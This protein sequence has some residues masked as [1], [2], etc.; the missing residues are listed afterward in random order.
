MSSLNDPAS[1]LG[2]QEGGGEHL[3]DVT[4]SGDEIQAANDSYSEQIPTLPVAVPYLEIAQSELGLDTQAALFLQRLFSVERYRINAALTQSSETE[5]FTH[6]CQT[7][8]QQNISPGFLFDCDWVAEQLSSKLDR[9]IDTDAESIM[10]LWLDHECGYA[11]SV[12]WFDH[13]FYYTTYPDVADAGMDA[14]YH[15]VMNGMDEGR[16]PTAHLMTVVN[17]T[18]THF[19]ESNISVADIIKAVPTDSVENYVTGASYEQQLKLFMPEL[20][21]ATHDLPGDYTP[22]TLF[23]HF[24]TVGLLS[25]KRPSALFNTDFYRSQVEALEQTS[26]DANEFV[27]PLGNNNPWLHWFYI[28]KEHNVVPTPLFSEAHYLSQHPDIGNNYEGNPFE[29]YLTTGHTEASRVPSVHFDA[30][31]YRAMNSDRKFPSL[32]LDYIMNGQFVPIAPSAG[33]HIEHFLSDDPYECSPAEKAAI[34]VS[35]KVARLTTGVLADMVARIDRLEPQIVRPYTSKFYR[36]APSFH[37]EVDLMLD[38]RDAVNGLN[39]KQYDTI[40][41]IPHCRMAGSAKIAGKL[42]QVLARIDKPEN[43]LVI[44]TDMS[45]F[46]RPDW[47]PE[48]VDVYDLNQYTETAPVDRKMRTLL[49]IVRGLRPKRLVNVNSNFGWQLTTAYGRQLS[50]WM[51][52]YFYLFCWDLDIKGNKGG[53]PIQWFLPTFDYCKAVFTDSKFLRDELQERYCITDQQRMKLQVLHTPAEDTQVNYHQ[54]LTQRVESKSV[55]RV[56]WSGRFDRQ[57]RTDILLAVAAAMPDIEF[58]VWGKVVLGDE[59]DPMSELPDNV[60]L[61]GHYSSID[62]VPIASCDCFLYT[63]EWDGLPTVLIEVGSRSVPIVA[64]AVGGVTDLITPS[65]GW[66][67]EDYNNAEAYVHAIEQVLADYPA[68]LEKGKA[69]REHTLTVCN[70]ELFEKRLAA[71]LAATG[72]LRV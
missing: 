20:Y 8:I 26:L 59:E 72:E 32:V 7:G 31:Y 64:S 36:M 55:K 54:S 16:I 56:F 58:W 46:E 17:Q 33:I 25:D 1:P 70:D 42:T 39:R 41:L 28:G 24:L 47:F 66:P 65:T 44:M 62:D 50:E 61:M 30:R 69:L 35:S 4:K 48:E 9:P 12:S 37:P 14:F 27:E 22:S 52:I 51:D 40:V 10:L 15:F 60:R 57:K 6:Y 45:A 2:Q 5:A 38:A 11:A 68:A 18:L 19:C 43:I 21:Q 34:T 23:A 3:S 49:D 13:D 71:V 67:V 29:H 63:A 53:Y